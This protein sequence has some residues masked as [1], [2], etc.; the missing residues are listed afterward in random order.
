MTVRVGLYQR[1]GK[2]KPWVIRWYGEYDPETGK[3]R[4][5]SKAYKLKLEAEEFQAEKQAELNRGGRRDKP[6]EISLGVFC[7]K[8][9]ET[10][11]RNHSHSDQQCYGNT[12]RQLKEFF[13]AGVL[14][15]K[16]DRQQAEAFISSRVR[17]AG[18]AKGQPL[19]GWSRAQHLKHCRALWGRA[20]K[21]GYVKENIF[22][23]VQTPT[24]TTRSWHYLKPKEFRKLLAVAP[25][26]RWRAIYW[27]LY[28]CGLRFGEA[29]NLTWADIDFDRG[30]VHIRNRPGTP[31]L[32]PFTVKADGRGGASKERSVVMPKPVVDALTAWQTEAP[33]GVPFVFLT[34]QRF[35]TVKLNWKRCQQGM[36]RVGATAPRPWQNRDMANNMLRDIKRQV[37]RAGIELTASMTVHTFR[38]SFGQNHADSGTPIHVL[39]QLMGHSSIT[40]TRE[41]YLHVDD[42]NAQAATDRYERLLDTETETG[43]SD[44]ATDAR[45]TPGA[46]KE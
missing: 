9:V 1:P 32:P 23:S 14:L 41:F 7:D 44:L 6:M 46:R 21:W 33:E 13:D 28:G 4:R 36:P 37:R 3:Q 11:L 18:R 40:T 39:Q 38:K 15:R 8:F 27:A 43:V 35:E 42:A 34:A 30:R 16:L 45:L 10:R 20:V 25:D 31:E 12:I 22:D 2:P 19:S 26:A 5:Y 24:K 17:I 29:F